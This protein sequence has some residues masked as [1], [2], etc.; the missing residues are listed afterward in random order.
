MIALRAA[1]YN[2][3]DAIWPL[4]R[5][6]FREG[7]AYAVDPQ[8]TQDAAFVYWMGAAETYVAETADGIVG[9]YYIKTNQP[10]GGAHICNC[11]YIVGAAARGCVARR[12]EEEHVF[13]GGE[14]VCG[15]RGRRARAALGRGASSVTSCVGATSSLQRRARPLGRGASSSSRRLRLRSR[16][17]RTTRDVVLA[18]RCQ[19]AKR[20]VRCRR[21]RSSTPATP[22]RPSRRS[23]TGRSTAGTVS[24]ALVV[25]RRALT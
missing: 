21:R 13:V 7:A 24:L 5:D 16:P 23:R 25:Q 17:R 15:A 2:D 6:V 12:R 10:G 19:S 4:L 18:V 3:W 1:T 20:N 14:K 9:T 11:G 8:I 22:F